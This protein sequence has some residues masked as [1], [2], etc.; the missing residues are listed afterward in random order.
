MGGGT[1]GEGREKT[2]VPGEPPPPPPSQPKKEW[3]SHKIGG[4]NWLLFTRVESSHSNTGGKSAWAERAASP[5]S[6]WPPI[7]TRLEKTVSDTLFAEVSSRGTT[8]YGLQG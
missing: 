6:H 3:E 2:G 8:L 5:L 7:E 1:W 4:E